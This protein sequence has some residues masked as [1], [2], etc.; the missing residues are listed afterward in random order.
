MAVTIHTN[1]ASYTPS[2]NEVVWRFSSNQTAN[3]NFVFIVKVYVNG[4]Y[5]EQHSVWPQNGIYSKFNA[6]DI[7]SRYTSLPSPTSDFEKDAG[8]NATIYIEVFERYGDPPSNQAS[9]TS[10][11]VTV[12]KA[13]LSDYDFIN[14]NSASYIYST[15]CKWLTRFPSGQKYYCAPTENIFAMMITNNQAGLFLEVELFDEDGNLI[16]ADS[17][18]VGQYK[19]TLLNLSQ[20][21]LIANTTLTQ[22][23]FDDA[24]YYEVWL[25]P[26]G[27]PTAKFRVYIDRT[28]DLYGTRRIIF[29]GSFGNIEAF[30]FTLANQEKRNV[31]PK[32]FERRFGR[33]NSSNEFEFNE[34]DGREQDYFIT[35]SGSIVL[36]SDWI[37]EE[38]QNWLV[39]ELYHAPFKLMQFNS[40][41][42]RVSL[43]ST[44]YQKKQRITD[45][46]F[47][48]IVEFALSDNRSSIVT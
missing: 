7:A 45:M 20:S 9:A 6:R 46:I 39:D 8:N 21:N 31:I 36:N 10:S 1:P 4:V 43:I 23:Q 19:I 17:S 22:D 13:A 35:S 16:I 14:Y 29:N 3:T 28:C 15:N 12:F 38:I 40:R 18:A 41:S 37:T 47:N 42:L 27:T 48:E 24:A 44:A 5:R 25:D 34:Q 30:S 26:G 32:K 33:W 2:D 11:T